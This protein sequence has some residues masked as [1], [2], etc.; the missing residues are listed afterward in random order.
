MG[1]LHQSDVHSSDSGRGG[2]CLSHSLV[3]PPEA[4]PATESFLLGIRYNWLFL[5]I[6]LVS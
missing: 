5:M 2:C 3:E 6:G 4:A 1:T